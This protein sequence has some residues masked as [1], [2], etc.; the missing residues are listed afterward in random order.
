MQEFAVGRRVVTIISD[1]PL[2]AA[3]IEK[4]PKSGLTVPLS[5]LDRE[6]VEVEAAE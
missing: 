2:V 5:A 1:V 6:A 4:Y 3:T